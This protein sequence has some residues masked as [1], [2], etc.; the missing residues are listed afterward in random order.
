MLTR[1]LLALALGVSSFAQSLSGA[2][3]PEP[4]VELYVVLDT[5]PASRTFLELRGTLPPADVTA[6]VRARQA[7][8]ARQQD[9]LAAQLTALGGEVRGRFDRLANALRVRLPADQLAALAALPGVRRLEPRKH[10]ELHTD[11]SV[12]FIGATNVWA[13][14]PLG[15][16]GAGIRIGIIDTGIDYLHADFGG[17]GDTDAFLAN[18]PAVIEPGTFPTARVVG[19]RD[20]VGN[21][22]H[23]SN[24]ATPD[25]DPLDCNGHGSHVAG[26]AA[27]QGV[28]TNRV[29]FTGPYTSGVERSRFLVSPGVAPRA[30]LYALKV[31]GC[32]GT[33]DYVLDALEWA[34][35]PN[36]DSDFSD[37]LD[38]LNLS[39]GSP[40]GL[41]R[42]ADLD[43]DAINTLAELGCVCVVSA[44][45][46]GNTF[47]IVGSPGIAERAITVAN[48]IDNGTVRLGVQVLSPPVIAATYLA[49]EAVFTPLLAGLPPVVG[50]V[51]YVEPNLACGT[52]ANAASLPGKIA[53]IDRG[54]CNFTDKILRAQN[55]GAVAVIMVNNIPGEP[56]AMGGTPVSPVTIPA[57]M[58]SQADGALLKAQLAAPVTVRLA[59]DVTYFLAELADQLEPS[60]SRGPAG[61][62]S[63]LKPDLAAPGGNILSARSG[64]GFQSTA[65]TGTSM[66]APHVAG[67]AGL[68][69]QL[70]PDWPVADLKAALLNTTCPTRDA[71]GNRYAE[72]R[73]GAGRVQVDDAARTLVTAKVAGVSGEVALNFGQLDLTAP[74]G[75]TQY[76]TLRNFDSLPVTLHVSVSNTVSENGFALTPLAASVEVPAGGT[77]LVPLLLTANPALFDRISEP[78]TPAMI[79][80]RP[81]ASLFEASGGVWFHGGAVP[82]HVPFYASLRAGAAFASDLSAVVGAVANTFPVTLPLHGASAHPQP[83]VSVFQLGAT[84]PGLNESD[85]ARAAADLLAV[86]AASDAPSRAAFAGTMVYF[87]VAT[88]GEWNSPSGFDARFHVEVDVNQDDV[89]DYILRNSSAGNFVGGLAA[90]DSA[91]DVFLPLLRTQSSATSS[92]NSVANAFPPNVRDTALFNNSVLVLPVRASALGLDGV[93]KTGFRYR[94]LTE[95]A[96]QLG[97]A[98][99]STPWIAFDAARPVV[100]ATRT[101]LGNTPFLPD[102]APA[103]LTVD[104][105]AAAANGL[106]PTSTVGVLL[107]HHFNPAGTRAEVVSVHLDSASTVPLLLL[108]PARTPGGG[109]VLRWT[110]SAAKTYSVLGATNLTAGFDQVLASGLTGTPPFNAFTN[111]SPS[112]AGALFYRIRAD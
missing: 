46:S 2:P 34:A 72:S 56:T 5:P 4:P 30:S 60:S 79:N 48:S 84:S 39:L 12:A 66:A 92:T 111:S 32:S 41:A 110:S 112:A 77:A 101:G 43:R 55:A 89:A 27:G 29:A 22:Y 57:V 21:A 83:L 9:D 14:S 37:R 61:P 49:S 13:A 6:A 81:R 42:D 17:A 16:T 80:G 51:V 103:T 95:A 99:D 8:I 74:L 109:H 105:A 58:L 59:G 82:L 11:T 71:S 64:S 10:Y 94:V 26:I 68:L 108:A 52:L 1:T 62:A 24:A 78:T 86:G 44:G 19:G 38:V 88:A 100:D 106:T 47:Y 18:N 76:I 45:N 28:L 93:T 87:A 36:G 70:H 31:F 54:S 107:L 20:F 91:N 96:Y 63:R 33:T 73:T 90:A 85:P 67:C 15:A 98:V 25:P 3:I 104:R 23:G 35:D 50:E 65:K 53:L 7:A 40:F 75:T 102:G 97:E 69:R